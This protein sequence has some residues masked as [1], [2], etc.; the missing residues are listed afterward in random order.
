MFRRF[1]PLP[2]IARLITLSIGL[3]MAGAKAG[4]YSQNFNA[5]LSDGS[6]FASNKASSGIVS[7]A[8]QMTGSGSTQ[9]I[10]A[11]RV[12][13]LDPGS[14]IVEFTV[15]FDLKLW[16][17][18]VPADG[19][20][21]GYGDLTTN[22]ADLSGGVVNLGE[23][24]FAGTRQLAVCF[25]TFDN[26]GGEGPAIEVFA[27]GVMVKKVSMGSASSPGGNWIPSGKTTPYSG[28]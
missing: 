22:A 8:L 1:D 13:D 27:N 3:S 18:N 24:G 21:I 9:A 7:G 16:S 10:S 6:I 2:R 23:K 14:E 12:P 15:R 28:L 5:P 19:L 11:F 26:G 4:N 17:A 20:A 25:D